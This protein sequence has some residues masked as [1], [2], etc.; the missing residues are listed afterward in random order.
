M[1]VTIK[2]AYDKPAKSDGF[3]VLV[4][5]LWPR[6]VTKTKAAID[7][8]AKDAAP[9][10]EL[11]TWFHGDPEKRYPEFAKKYRVE[12]TKHKADIRTLFKGH[13]AVTLVTAVK[14]V[15]HSHIPTLVTFLKQ[16]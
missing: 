10:S 8:W 1:K 16:F 12:L 11:R 2:R 4:D 13:K 3:R 14:D 15:D 5:R 6:G 7:L 9:S